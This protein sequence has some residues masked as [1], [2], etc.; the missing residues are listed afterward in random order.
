MKAALTNLH[1]LGAILDS[2]GADGFDVHFLD[3]EGFRLRSFTAVDASIYGLGDQ[4]SAEMVACITSQR[5][6]LFRSGQRLDFVES[7]VVAI[8]APSAGGVLYCRN[9]PTPGAA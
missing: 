9:L 6:S 5:R 1:R 3:G 7:D 2:C 4:W 8:H